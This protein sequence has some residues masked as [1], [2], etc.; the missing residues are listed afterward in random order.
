MSTHTSAK[1][2]RTSKS[3]DIAAIHVLHDKYPRMACSAKF[4]DANSPSLPVYTLIMSCILQIHG[5]DAKGDA[6]VL[7]I[8]ST[9]SSDYY[10]LWGHGGSL[11]FESTK[12]RA[13]LLSVM[14][15]LAQP[16]G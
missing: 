10:S 8:Q 7:R 11:H 15:E 14:M 1:I 4:Q 5:S 2:F 9:G 16:S 6:D 3:I 13:F 12:V